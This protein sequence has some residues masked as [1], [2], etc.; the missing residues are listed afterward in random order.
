[1]VHA[2]WQKPSTA[3]PTGKIGLITWDDPQYHYAMDNG[4][5]KA[6]HAHGLKEE[7]VRY[8]AVPAAAGSIADASAAVSSAVLAFQQRGIDHVFIG[9]GAAGI[10]G[11]VGLTLL[12]LQNANSQMY[13]PRYGFNGNNAPDYPNHPQR[14]LVGMRAIETIDDSKDKDA[15]IAVNAERERCFDVMKRKGLPVGQEQTQGVAILACE[16]VWFTQAALN[17]AG[18]SA[19]DRVIPAA[20]GLGTSYRSVFTFGTRFDPSHHDGIY[21]VRDVVYDESCSCLKYE[22]KPY[23]P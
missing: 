19:L 15:G 6:L 3:W 7:D 10:F 14:Q 23:A 17:R 2:G 5:L 4:Y 18:D 13:Y 22:S 16:A 8:V 1:M 20:E 12:F 21:L 9:D 11:G